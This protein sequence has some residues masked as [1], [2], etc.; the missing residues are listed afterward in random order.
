MRL[1]RCPEMVY[2]DR[3]LQ[4][5]P[6]QCIG[7]GRRS[8]RT[9]TCVPDAVDRPSGSR[10]GLSQTSVGALLRSAAAWYGNQRRRRS[11]CL[12]P[13]RL[14]APSIYHCVCQPSPVTS[15][16]APGSH[17]FSSVVPMGTECSAS[18][19]EPP[20]GP[21]KRLDS[22]TADRAGS[23][24]RER[25]QAEE[26]ADIGRDQDRRGRRVGRR[27]RKA[28]LRRARRTFPA[29]VSHGDE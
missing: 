1:G 12:R 21:S 24:R 25:V 22:P 27:P 18:C 10:A 29:S 19:G 13:V 3:G 14:V 20:Q 7:G 5:I 6:V 11:S 8:L 28:S 9:R 26:A 2:F 23:S 17:A 15:D 4:L 16:S